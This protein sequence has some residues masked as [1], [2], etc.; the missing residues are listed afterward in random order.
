[1]GLFSSSKNDVETEIFVDVVSAPVIDIDT[2]SVGT[3]ISGS[4]D[5]A[6]K[7]AA[8]V[9]LVWIAARVLL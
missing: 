2:S 4:I 9:A 3:A 8:F 6:V 5:K 1:M 7:T